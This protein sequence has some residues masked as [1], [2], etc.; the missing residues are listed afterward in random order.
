MPRGA[1][2]YWISLEGGEG[3][4]KTT[5]AALL[6]EALEGQG[7]R[8]VLTREPGGSVGAEKIRELIV[9]GSVDRWDPVCETLLIMAARA[10]H[11]SR[12]IT[13][14]LARGEIVICD[15]FLDSTRVYQGIAKGLGID[16][17]DSMHRQC[18]GTMMPDIRFYLDIDPRA[19]LVRTGSRG[20][21]E[22]RFES[23]DMSFHQAL[24]DGFLSLCQSD[25]ARLKLIDAQQPQISVHHAIMAHLSEVLR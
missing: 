14:A 17:V 6:K 24:R 3:A 21:N 13:P 15:R 19:G 1:Q 22:T 4:G 18:F 2:G 5:Q 9:T 8:V 25:H 11:L 20:G 16:W 7:H 23:M 10:D 12:T